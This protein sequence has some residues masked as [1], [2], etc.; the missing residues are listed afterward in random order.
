[1]SLLIHDINIM[2]ENE[3]ANKSVRFFNS[4]SQ[5]H[6]KWSPLDTTIAATMIYMHVTSKA[7]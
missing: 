3:L 6:Q 1:M 4:I 7:I 2:K 5:I